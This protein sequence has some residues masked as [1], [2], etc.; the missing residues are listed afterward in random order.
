MSQPIT[1]K[2]S[3]EIAEDPTLLCLFSLEEYSSVQELPCL[4]ALQFRLLLEGLF[5]HISSPDSW[6]KTR[7]E[8]ITLTHLKKSRETTN[9]AIL[10]TDGVKEGLGY[11]DGFL[12][13]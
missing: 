9:M 4:G 5:C 11:G 10:I 3:E 1:A 6:G 13:H 8:F 12:S 2:C 7:V